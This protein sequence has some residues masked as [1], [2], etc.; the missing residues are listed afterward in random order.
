M[1][2]II[3]DDRSGNMARKDTPDRFS[4]ENQQ[5]TYEQLQTEVLQLRKQ[6]EQLQEQLA[7]T[8]SRAT[9]L[10]K[11]NQASQR[12]LSTLA[13]DLDDVVEETKQAAVVPEQ[14]QVAQERA[15]ELIRANQLLKRSID[16]LVSTTELEEFAG[17]ILLEIV[18]LVQGA[19]GAIFLYD[20]PLHVMRLYMVV[21]EGR[22]MRATDPENQGFELFQQPIPAEKTQAWAML[23]QNHHPGLVVLDR[24]PDKA[25]WEETIAWH[26]QKG[27]QSTL[28]FPLKLANQP[29]GFLGL[30]FRSIPD[31]P[32]ETLELMQTLVHQLTLAL[33]LARI[34]EE[35][36]QT[37]IVEERNRLAREIHDTLAQSFTSILVRLQTA[38][39]SL[40]DNPIEAQHH[41]ALAGELA[42]SGLLEARRSVYELRPRPLE[43]G[44]LVSALTGYLHAM[45]NRT[46][47]RGVFHSQGDLEFIPAYIEVELFRIAQEAINNA[48]KHAYAATLSVEL[49]CSNGR[50]QLF[51]QDDGRGFLL[52]NLTDLR[53]FGLLS[54]QE[55]AYRIG[56]QFTINTRL[57]EGT[58]VL[59]DVEFR[60]NREM[61]R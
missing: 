12:S 40:A 60:S 54:M 23:V 32:E 44:D 2:E 4:K 48:C 57:G 6:I 10:A 45:T 27:H 24:E 28:C 5:L 52:P 30:A 8:Q 41:L 13:T 46:P 39:L 37:A 1:G 51:V 11:A 55:R 59:V 18:Q 25:C 47:I 19:N 61:K 22:V 43:E 34:A 3:D 16:R 14:Q 15:A 21:N 26:R 58:Q 42:R 29:W 36:Q 50:L 53:S 17:S 20:Q 38:S 33:Q 7:H 56:G 9:E 31:L 35:N 49:T